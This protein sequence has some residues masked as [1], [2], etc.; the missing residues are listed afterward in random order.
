MTLANL[1][2]RA[3]KLAIKARLKHLRNWYAA[4]FLSYGPPQLLQALRALGVRPGD[5]VMLHSAY[6]AGN[7][8]RGSISDLIDTFIE[9]VGPEGHLLMV[10]M[11]YRNA[12]LDWLLSGRRFDVR[13]TPSMMGMV[14][15]VFRRRPGVLRSLHPTHPILVHG[16]K[17]ERFIVAHPNC[18]HP[19]GPGT[20]FDE[21]AKADGKVV[22]FNVPIDTFTFFHYLEH[23]VSPTLPFALYTD[24]LF[25][26][27][28][29]DA[30]GQERVVR[31]Y[32]FARAA[33]KRRR[34][35]RLYE[36]LHER[37]SVAAQRV[38]ASR[39]LCVR[40][41][42]AIACTRELQQQGLLFYDMT[43]T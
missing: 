24:T 40:V 2:P 8:L 12:A 4:T 15:E 19:C 35:E 23:L 32:A 37:G 13:K 1:L 25:E 17:A 26:A 16:P 22:F 43:T 34:P 36:A 20:P 30:T 6:S 14:S 5:T 11:P 18:L 38:G 31:T 39:L 41:S 27:Q 3:W 7:G 9:A 10:S 42:D 33:M 21:V 29:L 28:V